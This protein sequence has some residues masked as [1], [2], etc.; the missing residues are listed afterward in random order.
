MVTYQ[1]LGIKPVIN[2]CGKM[3]LLGATAVEPEVAEAMALAS[4]HYVDVAAL[5]RKAGEWIARLSG[6]EAACVTAG[7]ASGIAMGAAA[8]IAGTDPASIQALPDPPGPKCEILVLAGHWI[9][10]VEMA[11][12][13]GAKLVRVGWV[14]G[15]A[16]EQLA[17][18]INERTAG[19]LYVISHHVV[20]KGML[21][22][23]DCLDICHGRGIPILVDAA[24]EEDLRLYVSM[25]A[26]LVTYS[27]G[28]A[29]GGPSF[30]LLCGKAAHIEACR[31]QFWGIARSMK[32]T[33]EGI[34]GL[35]TALELYV[36]ADVD[37]E[38][39]R[40]QGISG[41]IA[42]GLQ[43]LPHVRLSIEQDE[44]GRNI[45]RVHLQLDETALGFTAFDLIRYLRSGEPAIITRDHKANLGI[46]MMDPRPLTED[47]VAVIVTRVRQF[48]AERG[49]S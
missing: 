22:L 34:M 33:K 24:A 19:F 23:K 42:A 27:G 46:L 15:V 17:A 21:S 13:G 9:N 41:Q 1:D 3:T 26:D 45:P 6:A 36:H 12:L 18:A 38:A 39:R 10:F 48:F 5:E 4:R 29:F 28:K 49:P 16:K 25:G 32:V 11:R 8:F 31:A 47:Q 43:G 44:A 2:A 37:A 35:L 7:A 40:R 30:G 14:N 20:Q